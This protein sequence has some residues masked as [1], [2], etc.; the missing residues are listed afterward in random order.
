MSRIRCCKCLSD[1]ADGRTFVNLQLLQEIL[2][3]YQSELLKSPVNIIQVCEEVLSNYLTKRGT[4]T[5]T[6][7]LNIMPEETGEDEGDELVDMA[8]NLLSTITAE[9]I[10]REITP[11]EITALSSCLSHLEQISLIDKDKSRRNTAR[12]V[13]SFIRA[14]IA[15][16]APQD[17]VTSQSDEEMYKKAMTYI[18]DPLVPIR[19]QGLSILRDLILK[20]SMAINT[21]VVLGQLIGLLQDEDSYVYL[22]AIKSIQTLADIHGH[23]ITQKLISE[24]TAHTSIESKLRIAET[25]AGVIRRMG[26]TFTGTFAQDLITH[27]TSVV[28][29][30]QDWRIRVSAIGLVSVAV[31]VCPAEAEPGIEM[32]LHLFRVNDLLFSEEGEGAAPLRRGAVAVIAGVLRGGG[33]DALGRYT[34]DVLRSIKYLARSDGDET[35]KELAQGVME[36]LSGVIETGTEETSHW[37]VRPR[38]QEL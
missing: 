15:M 26:E 17:E 38:I 16:T 22:N 35:V 10:Q 21:D 36:M 19:A 11:A 31:E 37:R 9:S 30:E 14:R 23:Q 29:R 1:R 3:R 32:A 34:R 7:I 28:S 24:Y 2:S 6:S 13:I 18:T 27:F 8:L 5:A 25:L 20:N 12:N 4:P 33:I